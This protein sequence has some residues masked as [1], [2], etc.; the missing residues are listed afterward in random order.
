MAKKQE[1]HDIVELYHKG[2]KAQRRAN[3]EYWLNC[4]FLRGNQWVHYNRRTRRLEAV[5]RRSKVQATINRLWPGSRTVISK[6]VQRPLQFEV[7]PNSADDTAIEGARVGDSIL[8]AVR[9]EHRWEDLRESVAWSTWKGGT[10]AICVDWNPKKGKP[11][12]LAEDGRKLPSG[13]TVETALSIAEFVIEPGAR[14]AEEARWWIKAQALPPEQVKSDYGLKN[15]PPANATA[16]LSSLERN[17][18][19]GALAGAHG[20]TDAATDIGLTL[21]LTYYERPNPARPKGRVEIVIDNETVWGPKEWPFPFV[22]Y[23]NIATMRETMIENTWLGETCVSAARPIQAAF[24]ASWSNILEHLDTV[25]A[26]KLLRPQSSIELAEQ[27]TDIIGEQIPFMDGMDKPA[28]M[29]PPQLPAWIQN[30][31]G[32]LM[33]QIDDLLGVHDVSRGSAPANIESGYGLAVLAE[34]DATPIGKLSSGTARLFSQVGSMVLKIYEA[35][36]KETRTAVVQEPGYPPDTIPWTGQT[37]AGQTEATVPQ[38]LITPRSRAAQGQMAE[39]LLQMGLITSIEEMSRVA[40]MPGERE[41]VAAVRPDVA[42]ARRENVALAQGKVRFPEEFDDH[43]IHVQEHNAYRKTKRYESLPP[44]IKNLFA[45]HVQAHQTVMAEQAAG[46]QAAMNAGGPAAASA[47]ALGGPEIPLADPN[48]PPP[49]GEQTVLDQLTGDTAGA[50]EFV[51]AQASA[52][53]AA[54]D[55]QEAE[56]DAILQLAA[57]AEGNATSLPV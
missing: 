12:A 41:L 2:L 49:P 25:G 55:Q 39:K 11:T 40:E 31:P 17:V 51:D 32:E 29:N 20:P 53:G 7:Q 56:R 6:L 8:H 26:A 38:D 18:L 54:V 35:E 9:D 30:T 46:Q 37:L 15:T 52:E 5:P 34:Q 33:V 19:A 57:I 13:D 45:A 10:A 21:V 42:R 22:D 28:Y 3:S 48:A 36:V 23:L 16:G 47:A 4:A 14:I 50:A 27:Y 24:N 43:Q 1:T 44:E